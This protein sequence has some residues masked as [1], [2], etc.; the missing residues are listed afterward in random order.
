MTAEEMKKIADNIN[1]DNLDKADADFDHIEIE[2]LNSANNGNYNLEYS[3]VPDID[4]S[5]VNEIR[6]K[7]IGTGFEVEITKGQNLGG[8][9]FVLN[10][11]W[12]KNTE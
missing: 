1:Q 10:I 11:D 3:F 2:I 6:N 12:S 9:C 5:V 4:Y 8:E 7:L